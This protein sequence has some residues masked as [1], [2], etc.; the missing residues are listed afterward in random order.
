MFEGFGFRTT[1]DIIALI[2][3]GYA[4]VY[5]VLGTGYQ[6]FKDT[7][8][9]KAEAEAMKI[10]EEEEEGHKEGTQVKLDELS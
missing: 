6:G 3:I 9:G 8:T 1:Q 2:C 10:A 7:F 4:V 5:L